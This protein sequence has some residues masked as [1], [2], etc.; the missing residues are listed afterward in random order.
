[1]PTNRQPALLRHYPL[2]VDLEIVP[3]F[4]EPQDLVHQ[5]NQAVELEVH[6]HY[7]WM[8]LYHVTVR[9][10]PEDGGGVGKRTSVCRY[11]ETWN[12]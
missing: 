6:Y 9:G 5:E 3:R 10:E 2:V 8:L 7:A 4:V 1:M 11:Q 12:R